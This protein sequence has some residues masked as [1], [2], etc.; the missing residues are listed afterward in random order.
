LGHIGTLTMETVALAAKLA[1]LKNF[2][3]LLKQENF[4]N[5]KI[6]KMVYNMQIQSSPFGLCTLCNKYM[7]H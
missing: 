1:D 6:F 7:K 5:Y 4:Q 3:T 2:K